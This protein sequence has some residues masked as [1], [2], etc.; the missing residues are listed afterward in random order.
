MI[1]KGISIWEQWDAEGSQTYLLTTNRALEALFQVLTPP[2]VSLYLYLVSCC[3][4]EFQGEV[5]LEQLNNLQGGDTG[6]LLDCL[7]ETGL[8]RVLAMDESL[9]YRVLSN[10]PEPVKQQPFS[11]LE[12]E[13]RFLLEL[14]SGRPVSE[15]ELVKG[16][17]M[18][19]APHRLTYN[20]RSE[21]EGIME[22]FSH[23]TIR[24][25]IRRVKKATDE[26]Q[27]MKPL[28]Y[29]RAIVR[30]WV[31]AGIHSLEDL[32]KADKL[33]RETYELALEFGLQRA[34]EM[35]PQHKKTL[36]SW[37][38]KRDNGDYGL[39]VDVAKL[40]IQEAI[41]RKRDGRPSLQYIENNFINPWKKARLS[42]V[43]E[44][45]EYLTSPGKKKEK[46]SD[47]ETWDYEEFLDH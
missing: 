8:L 24:E 40:A 18:I 34:R 13:E 3:D 11:E 35:T 10:T 29:L 46:A 22:T 41:R 33:H 47:D 17:V 28:P 43:E 21:I 9:S 30:D 37:I 12:Q 14:L 5:R 36:L 39:S 4:R 2:A 15:Q 45:R 42:S 1:G 44:A 27:D 19:L 7:T 26:N 6:P 23:E 25:L 20:L 16:L 31:N 38:T 32:Q